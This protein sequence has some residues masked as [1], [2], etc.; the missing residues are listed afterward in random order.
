METDSIKADDEI[1]LASVAAEALG[2]DSGDIVDA[3]KELDMDRYDDEDDD[4]TSCVLFPADF[5]CLANVES[6]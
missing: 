5:F 4:G 6:H 1:A 3:F 2:K